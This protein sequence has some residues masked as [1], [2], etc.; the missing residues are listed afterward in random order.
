MEK[1]ITTLFFTSSFEDGREYSKAGLK[2]PPLPPGGLIH[3]PVLVP[4]PYVPLVVVS[5]IFLTF[6]RPL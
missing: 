4:D 6:D 3:D 1:A 5:W 2:T